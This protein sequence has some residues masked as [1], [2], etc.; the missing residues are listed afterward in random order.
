MLLPRLKWVPLLATLAGCAGAP[1]NSG[2][3][4]F[5]D[6]AESVFR[7]QNAIISRLM[8]LSDSDLLPDTDNFEDT[9]QEMHDACHLLNEYAEHEADGESMGLRFKAK[10]RSS[11]EGCDASVQKMEGL[12]SNID[13]VPTPPHGQR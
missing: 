6:Y 10:V 2:M 1:A 13:P 12:L 9:E 7:H 11:I 3:D 4:S 8:M 5:A